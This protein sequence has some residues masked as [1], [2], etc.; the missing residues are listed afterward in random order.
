MKR[1]QTVNSLFRY[2]TD[3]AHETTYHDDFTDQDP[4]LFAF[5]MISQINKTN[6]TIP[7][8]S[9]CALYDKR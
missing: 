4:M 6:S 7:L 9:N 3:C 8:N 1:K 5:C 2:W